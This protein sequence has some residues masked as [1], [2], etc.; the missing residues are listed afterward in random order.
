MIFCFRFSDKQD[1]LD[2][3]RT[4]TFLGGLTNT[5][6]GLQRLR[7]VF[8]G[9]DNRPGA[10][11]VTFIIT[12]GEPTL[13]IDLTEPEAQGAQDEGIRMYAVGITQSVNENTLRYLSSSPRT[14]DV[15]YFMSTD[16]SSLR[17][18]VLNSL[19]IEAC[20]TVSPTIPSTTPSEYTTALC[21]K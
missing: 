7:E 10:P 2:Q 3:I 18:Q 11:D 1:L 15:N 12:D 19:L 6:E 9:S 4:I 14:P 20:A 13:N 17:R 16:F 8:S 5:Y 21:T